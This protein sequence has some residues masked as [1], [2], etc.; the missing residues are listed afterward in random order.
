MLGRG[1][2]SFP[3]CLVLSSAILFL[4]QL[5]ACSFNPCVEVIPNITYR[6]MDL[7]LSG[8]PAEIPPSTENLDLSF[9]PLVSLTS[10]YFSEVPELRLLDLTRCHIQTIEDYAFK[11]LH[12]LLTLIL[13][14]NPLQHLGPT[15]FYGLASLQR[16]IAVEDDI[17]SLADLPIGHLHTL[18]E[19]NV[20]NN[21]V[22]SLKLPGYFSHLSLLRFLS[23]KSNRIS[24]ISTGDLA[25]LQGEKKHNLTLVLSLNDI[26]CIQPGS[27]EGILLHE[28]SLRA[29]FENTGLMKACI[30]GLAGLQVNRLV[31]GE[32]RN[33][34]RVEDFS[35]GLLDGL[36]QVQ[37]QEFVFISFQRFDNCTDTLFD[38]LVNASTIR[39]V[40][41]S[42]DQVSAVPTASRIH[43]LE[44][45]TC[46]FIEVPAKKL[47]SFK[48]LRVLRIT[49][50]KYL[51]GFREKFKDLPN[52]EV[53]DLSV[54]RLSFI[55]CCDSYLKRIPKLK[56]LNLSFNSIISVTGGLNITE[57]VSL[58][59]RHSKL[60][61]FGSFPVFHCL[62]KLI[63][64]DISYTSSHIASQCTFSGLKSL[65]VLKMAG[66][67]FQ[68]N[69]LGNS[70]MNL[71]QLL[72]L[73]VSSCKLTQV[74]PS[75]FKSLTKLQELNISHNKLL[76]F[77]PLAYKP[78]Q[79]L[80]VLDFSSNQLTVLTEKA[81]GSL[82]SCL[83]HLD[84]SYNLFD[85]SC[86][87]L[88]FLKWAKEHG[89]LLKSTQLMV[90]NNPV[91]MQN[92]SVLSFDL[93]SCHLSPVEWVMSVSVPFAGI[94][95]VILIYK[96]YF[97]LY[98]GL[99]LHSGCRRYTDRNDTYDAF[100]IHSSKDIEWVR[101]ELAEKLEGGMP[102][103]Q[104]RLH[105]RDFI[106]GVPITTN[107][108]QEGFLS[109][110]RVIAVISN[111]FMESKWCSFELEIAQSWQFVDGK[112]SLIM[113]VL[114][115][116]DKVLLR[117]KLE[118]SR[119]LRRNTYLEWR[120]QEISRHLF[121][122]QLRTALLDDKT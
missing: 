4:S 48:E 20:A 16:L 30:Q 63:Y 53:L 25:A 79:A 9:N 6:C 3:T 15:A 19:L 21:Q 103:F 51:T 114:E 1:A 74:S 58:D 2:L 35:N 93:S 33:I 122:R 68:D 94:L 97:L 57:L 119:Y 69:N 70:L 52:L 61:D 45:N 106:P 18:Q 78:L 83:V 92:M 118:L 121:W 28:L 116:V 47:S 112:A 64:L 113:I 67:S 62:G 66:N 11:D 102:P 12:K 71:T 100:V 7:N 99:V 46:K 41:L 84:L 37:L 77:D 49:N 101:K 42:L 82:P 17:S 65:Q 39:L 96:Y 109:S 54:N 59:F 85:C 60:N 89:E 81:M 72:T 14:A 29:C 115:E 27:F 22:D 104:L 26:K 120:D 55:Q 110:R 24:S 87:H 56:H 90:C 43:H 75:T 23:L 117:R 8:V 105:Y 108:I 76:A 107:I 88:S 111:H 31:L 10:N 34:G 91:H 95:F 13:T 36:C 38:C 80:T 44:F 98:Y 40:D 5:M 50:S 73:D 32:F 86:N